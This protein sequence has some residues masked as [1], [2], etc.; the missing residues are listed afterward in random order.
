MNKRIDFLTVRVMSGTVRASV[1]VLLAAIVGLAVPRPAAAAPVATGEP[2][3]K[4]AP[5]V[6]ATHLELGGLGGSG[7]TG[8]RWR[9]GIYAGGAHDLAGMPVF[10]NMTVGYLLSDTAGEPS[11]T[12]RSWV[13]VVVCT[14]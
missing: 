9:G 4:R 5:F 2:P 11:V 3:A 13:W 14:G 10:A 7:L 6:S 12:W 1:C 8:G